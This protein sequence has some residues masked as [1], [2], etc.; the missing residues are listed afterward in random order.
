M[1]IT[2][3]STERA[4][5]AP[6]NSNVMHGGSMDDMNFQAILSGVASSAVFVT[7]WRGLLDKSFSHALKRAEQR[8]KAATEAEFRL[9]TKITDERFAACRNLSRTSVLIREKCWSIA[10]YASKGWMR[11]YYSAAASIYD[12]S[13]IIGSDQIK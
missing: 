7:I 4:N 1:S 2:N 6:V 9:K 13:F 10:L 3:H 11:E 12:L 8:H 5:R